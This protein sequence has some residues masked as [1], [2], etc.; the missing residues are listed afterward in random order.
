MKFCRVCRVMLIPDV[1]WYASRIKWRAYICNKCNDTK[2]L[3]RDTGRPYRRPSRGNGS[4]VIL[5]CTEH[6]ECAIIDRRVVYARGNG[7]C[8][9][10]QKSKVRKK[11][12]MD[13]IIPVSKG[14]THCY[15]NLQPSHVRCNLR[16]G[17]KL[18]ATQ[19]RG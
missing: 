3:A 6:L 10:C 19:P 7:M 14:G 4:R 13:H 8:G 5:P 16:K 2:R 17:S 1:N 9:I 15:Y 12:H 18:I 11:W